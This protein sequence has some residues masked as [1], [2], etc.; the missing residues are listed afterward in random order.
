MAYSSSSSSSG[1]ST[2]PKKISE[3]TSSFG[4]SLYK[5]FNEIP[6]KASDLATD[7][8]N[9]TSNAVS[10]F[11]KPPQAQISVPAPTAPTATQAAGKYIRRK[12]HKSKSRKYKTNKSKSKNNKFRRN[13]TSK[14][15][16]YKK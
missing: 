15:R 10:S 6:Q 8:K 3:T 2:I 7:I 12:K 14:N 16:K 5:M 1:L 11:S 9:T 4:S 13:R